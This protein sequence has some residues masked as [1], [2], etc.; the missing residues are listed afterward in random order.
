MCWLSHYDSALKPLNHFLSSGSLLPLRHSGENIW[1]CVWW[2]GRNCPGPNRNREDILF[3]NP[4]SGETPEGFS[5]ANPRPGS[6]GTGT[7]AFPL[8][9]LQT[10][11]SQNIFWCDGIFISLSVGPCLNS[12]KRAGNPGHQRLQR[13]HQEVDSSLLLWWHLIHASEWVKI[14]MFHLFRR[15]NIICLK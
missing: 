11:F 5:S 14:Q 6:K 10:S 15:S 1:P 12:N 2:R 4:F 3:R 8:Q 13:H 9:K 7:C